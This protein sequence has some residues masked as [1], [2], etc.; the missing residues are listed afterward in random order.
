M[1]QQPMTF[2]D[3]QLSAYLDGELPAAEAAALENALETDTVLQS[4][5][6]RLGAVDRLL[7][8]AFDE[9]ADG[10]AP[11]AVL[12]LLKENEPVTE[13]PPNTASN[14]VLFPSAR[15]FF[16][17]HGL[18]MAA[19]ASIALVAASVLSPQQPTG[20]SMLALSEGTEL[21]QFLEQQPSGERVAIGDGQEAEVVLSYAQASGSFCREFALYDRTQTVQAVA[22]N[23]DGS[24][25]LQVAE[26]SGPIQT[27]GQS[28]ATASSAGAALEA[29]VDETMASDAL[30]TE[31][32]AEL[33]RR[34]WK[35][36][37]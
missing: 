3:A 11:D 22:C 9:I 21:R 15:R 5:L 17:Q 27:D 18:P 24:W 35:V 37:D 7:T 28:Y 13:Q 30:S 16:G 14:V 23:Q 12:A 1:T 25:A 36:Q 2:T 6:E 19:A 29:F 31:Q 4:R 32:E 33:I 8:P 20:S 26:F 34:G 10:P